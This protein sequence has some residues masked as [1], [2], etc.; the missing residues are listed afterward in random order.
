MKVGE[1]ESPSWDLNIQEVT[2]S[3]TSRG[4]PWETRCMADNNFVAMET[5]TG[6][7]RRKRLQVRDQKC[8]QEQSNP[9]KL[10][11]SVV[12]TSERK[13]TSLIAVTDVVVKFIP[14]V[15]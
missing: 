1:T 10:A 4:K 8:H 15:S 3:K 5:L 14:T 11:A 13:K 2:I 6:L 12:T 9:M 7:R